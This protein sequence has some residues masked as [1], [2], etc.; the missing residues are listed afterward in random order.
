MSNFSTN[1]PRCN[2]EMLIPEEFIGKQ[3]ECPHCQW[4]FSV[5][6][7][8]KPTVSNLDIFKQTHSGVVSPHLTINPFAIAMGV[9]AGIG[10]IGILF[11]T[12]RSASVLKDSFDATDILIPILAAI[13]FLAILVG[14]GEIIN[15]LTQI[16]NKK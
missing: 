9:A 15:L 7:N 2:K 5:S 12:I 11:F 3:I 13:P 6:L 8:N 4:I 14:L 1:C 16:K 10:L